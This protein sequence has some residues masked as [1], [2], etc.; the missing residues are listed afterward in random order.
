MA[1]VLPIAA[2]NPG[3][4]PCMVRVLAFVPATDHG[5]PRLTIF[6]S[7]AQYGAACT[8]PGCY[9]S[10]PPKASATPCRF[11]TACTRPDCHFSH[12]PGHRVKTFGSTFSTQKNK[13]ATFGGATQNG[14]EADKMEGKEDVKVGDSRMSAR[15]K[16]F[17]END[18]TGERE[19]I[20]DGQTVKAD[21]QKTEE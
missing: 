4:K 8:R 21:D 15:M 12:P 20:V 16:R 10:H 11:G 5:G 3:A 18:S 1:P 19:R 17:M 6:M 9:F 2:P 7:F 13:S 14:K